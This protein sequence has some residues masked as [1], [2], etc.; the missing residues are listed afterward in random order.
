MLPWFSGR[1]T[2]FDGDGC[3]DGFEDDDKD[4]D[5]VLD[6][7]DR[8]PNTP[9]HY[10][11]ISNAMTDFDGDGCKDGVED[12]DDDG[13]HIPNILDHCPRTASGHLSDSS[14]CAAHQLQA[15]VAS[16]SNSGFGGEA[17]LHLEQWQDPLLSPHVWGQPPRPPPLPPQQSPPQHA[18]PAAAAAAASAQLGGPGS[19]GKVDSPFSQLMQ[20]MPSLLKSNFFETILGGGFAWLLGSLWRAIETLRTQMRMPQ[21]PPTTDSVRQL[22]M[23]VL[24]VGSGAWP[25]VR[26]LLVK[27]SAYFIFLLGVYQ[28]RQLSV[29]L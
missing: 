9:Q 10:V 2:D 6:H 15:P 24:V 20:E 19:T 12:L 16:T 5:G 23:Q 29:Q 3:R 7:M 27:A 8:C 17:P 13:D 25:V 22:S 21:V 11:F 18:G 26:G 1:A 28:Y 14:G 4:N